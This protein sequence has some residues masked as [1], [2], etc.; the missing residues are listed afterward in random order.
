MKPWR[1]VDAA[2]RARLRLVEPW[3]DEEALFRV[4]LSR[5]AH[6][7]ALPDATI[8]AGD[9]VVEL[10]LWNEHV[11]P[12][13]PKGPDLAWAKAFER[14]ATASLKALAALLPSDTRFSPARALRGVSSAFSPSRG[15][16]TRKLLERIGFTAIAV[17]SARG[18]TAA[19]LDGVY[20][21]YLLRA[22]AARAPSLGRVLRLP[23]AELWMSMATL[24][25]RYGLPGRSGLA[26]HP[27]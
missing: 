17:D 4:R 21:W 16:G 26:I 27:V 25:R 1:L 12:M 14:R 5:A 19:L 9:P 7:V 11:P 3:Q 10:H 23:R 8:R 15:T 20:A 22:F 2:M 6:A 18:S 13:A 24:V